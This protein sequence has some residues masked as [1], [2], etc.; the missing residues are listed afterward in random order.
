MQN[1]VIVGS[2]GHAKVIID[3]I[4]KQ[5][6]FHI[7]GL[8]DDL[9]PKGEVCFGYPI[10]GAQK[11]LPAIVE[12]LAVIGAIVAIGDNWVR[13]QTVS[14]IRQALPGFQ[15]VTAIH[16]SAQIARGVSMG[17]GTVVMAGAVINSDSR[18]G[19]HCIINTR[20]SVDHDNRIGDFVTIAPGA[21]TGGNVTIGDYS[22]LA[23]GAKIIHN[24]KIGEHTVIGAGSTVLK[25]IPAN[26]V[27]FGA[28][29]KIR[30]PRVARE[31]Y[32]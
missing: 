5:G 14:T 13:A 18:I 24:I 6:V 22:V 27:A 32:L 10:L 23:L 19:E 15:F 28:P 9:K 1:I 30:R 3:I 11:D 7:P 12:S 2:S 17:A 4:E 21:I 8:I 31:K 25:D 29:A 20:A 16:P 26:V